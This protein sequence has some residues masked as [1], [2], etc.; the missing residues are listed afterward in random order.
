MPSMSKEFVRRALR[1]VSYNDLEQD[2]MVGSPYGKDIPNLMKGSWY[3]GKVV[4]F[5][6]NKDGQSDPVVIQ[7]L[8]H[9]KVILKNCEELP[10]KGDWVVYSVTDIRFG[11]YSSFALGDFKEVFKGR[12]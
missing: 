8:N 9:P 7:G 4:D 1:P 6:Q 11:E 3:V 10:A 12:Y 5:S 2:P